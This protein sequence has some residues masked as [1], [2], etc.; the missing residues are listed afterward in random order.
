[1]R[2]DV[3][4][5]SRPDEGQTRR[6]RIG[7]PA[8]S[9]YRPAIPIRKI[10][11]SLPLDREGFPA[12]VLI[13]GSLQEGQSHP[14][15]AAMKSARA[16]DLVLW[17]NSPCRKCHADKPTAWGTSTMNPSV[18]SQMILLNLYRNE[19]PRTSCRLRNPEGLLHLYDT[20]C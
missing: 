10:R 9:F 13:G 12:D 19:V 7:A 2:C 4:H 1:M 14:T 5:S 20:T 3:R 18:W 16:S 11:Q 6:W 17:F 8:C 15:Q